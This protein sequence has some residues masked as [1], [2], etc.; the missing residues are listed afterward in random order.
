M[1]LALSS[2]PSCSVPLRQARSRELSARGRR[3]PVVA[4]LKENLAALPTADGIK[5]VD[6]PELG[7]SIVAGPGK[8]AS[9]QIYA[10]LAEKFGGKLNADAAQEALSI[11]D[12]FVEEARQTPG[13][14]PNIDLLFEVIRDGTELSIVVVPE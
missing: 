13:S 8:M 11:Y 5:Q 7:H 4:G 2:F 12:E 1:P 3:A 9:V 6:I 10:S 14:H